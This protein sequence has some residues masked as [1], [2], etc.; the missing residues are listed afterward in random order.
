MAC[1]MSSI[2]LAGHSRSKETIDHKGDLGDRYAVI[3]ATNIT[4]FFS[5]YNYIIEPYIS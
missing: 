4:H 1:S 5:L 2:V 3:S